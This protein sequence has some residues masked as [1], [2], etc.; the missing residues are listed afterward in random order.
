MASES[1][2]RT[3][4]AYRNE[5]ASR[6]DHWLFFVVLI[7]GSGGI[8][9]LK[10]GGHEQWVVTSFPVAM[11]AM[12]ALYVGRTWRYLLRED[13]AGDNLYYLGFLYTLVSL[14]YSLFLF[15]GEEESTQRIIENFGVAL[16]TT[17]VGLALRVLFNQMREDPVEIE[18]EA[19]LDLREAASKLK[20]ELDTSV[21]EI[22]SF[23]RATAQS[24]AEGMAEISE[25]SNAVLE[26]HALQLSG[27][28]KQVVETI[29]AGFSA[30][31]ENQKELNVASRNTV[32]AVDRLAQQVEGINVPGDL[33][34]RKL[35][36]VLEVLVEGA[37]NI[38]SHSQS[39]TENSERLTVFI[40]GAVESSRLLDQ[41]FATLV[42]ESQDQRQHLASEIDGLQST[43]GNLRGVV[44]DSVEGLRDGVGLQQNIL[45]RLSESAEAHLKVAETHRGGLEEEL[46]KS[47]ALVSELHEALV[48]MT[49]LM[50]DRLDER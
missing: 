20:A 13:R 10:E 32:N 46:K 6:I 21:I 4:V 39:Q 28:V 40:K 5:F 24:L 26:A 49:R 12:Y 30:L 14:A 18:R 29:D 41:R 17:I 48:S 36:P 23:R 45:T 47:R 11:M 7:I 44:Q 42:E 9:V 19:R 33:I 8:I 50:I 16:A 2:S 34:E 27:L 15:A 22:N 37:K 35:T 3:F 43:L 38:T 25:K 31:N 1:Q